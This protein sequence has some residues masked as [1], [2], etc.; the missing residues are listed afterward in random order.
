M[1]EC[2][3]FVEDTR[4]EVDV[5]IEE[6][7]GTKVLTVEGEVAAIELLLGDNREI[8]IK[9]D[10]LKETLVLALVVEV[11]FGAN[12]FVETKGDAV[13]R[14]G[15][16][17]HNVNDALS[18]VRILHKPSLSASFSGSSGHK[19]S[20]PHSTPQ[21]HSHTLHLSSARQNVR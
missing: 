4:P 21:A 15:L 19:S 2:F 14:I 16:D 10:V 6:Y 13:R 5:G 8:D 9:R 1:F 7:I 3:N 11:R 17:V 20:L 12:I 18:V